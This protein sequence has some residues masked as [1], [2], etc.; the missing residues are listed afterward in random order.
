MMRISDLWFVH[1]DEIRHRTHEFLFARDW[2]P[3]FS[4]GK[5]DGPVLSDECPTVIPYSIQHFGSHNLTT[6]YSPCSSFIQ[7]PIQNDSQF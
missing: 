2:E 4:L 3:P 7:E 1:G 6:V 5:C